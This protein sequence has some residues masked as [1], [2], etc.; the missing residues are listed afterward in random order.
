MNMSNKKLVTQKKTVK[1]S[2]SNLVD[3]IDNIIS[4]ALT[5]KEK[6]WVNE[7]NV[8]QAQKTAILENK[9]SML[10]KKLN[11]LVESKK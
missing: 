6:E 3:I 10:N 4:E 8:R 1:I 9:I 2:E 11:I 7:A 5:I